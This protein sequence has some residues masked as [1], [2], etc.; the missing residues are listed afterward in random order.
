M[1][2]G[3]IWSLFGHPSDHLLEAIGVFGERFDGGFGSSSFVTCACFLLP[4]PA[5][6]FAFVSGGF[7][8]CSG[9]SSSLRLFLVVAGWFWLFL[10]GLGCFLLGLVVSGCFWLLLLVCGCV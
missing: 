8:F 2:L 10:V 5:L 3:S 4:L 9:C 7:C 1:I 6:L